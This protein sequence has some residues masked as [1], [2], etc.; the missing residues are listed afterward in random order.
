MN[1]LVIL[2]LKSIL[3]AIIGSSFYRWFQST[4]M[5]IWFQNKLDTFMNYLS[6]KYDIEIAK[7]EA[8]WRKDYPLLSERMDNIENKIKELENDRKS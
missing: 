5:G 7:K 2:T 1:F 4:K 3:S 8:K 6:T